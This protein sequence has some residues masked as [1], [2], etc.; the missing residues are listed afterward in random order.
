MKAFIASVVTETNT[1]AP[2]PTGEE[3]FAAYG[4]RKDTSRDPTGSHSEPLKV[5]RERAEVAGHDVVESLCAFAQPSGKTL[6]RVY[7]A[8]R[9]E[10]LDDLKAAGH[11]DVVLLMLHG[12]MVAEGYDDTEGDLIA[13]VRGVAP[14][15]VIGVELDPHCHLTEAMVAGADLI[16]ISKE[17][18]HVDFGERAVE[19]ADLCL[20][21]ARGELRPRAALVDCRMIG[22]YPTFDAP[23]KDIVDALKAAEMPPLLSVSLA[24]GF[25][26]ADVPEMGTRVL[27]Y[28]DDDA[29]AAASAAERFA[30]L[31]YD[32]R[33]ALYP[34]YPTISASLARA[35]NLEG[36]VVLGDFAD[37][38][39]GGAPGDATFFLREMLASGTTGAVVGVFWDPFVVSICADAGVGARLPVRLGGKC[40]PM[41][42][43]PLD[44]DVE[45]MGV[46]ENHTQGV[47]GQRESMGRSV[48]LRAHGND[49]AVCSVRTQTYDPDAFSGLGIDLEGRRLLVVKS[50]NHYRAGFDAIADHL[51]HVASPGTMSADLKSLP[52]TRLTRPWFPKVDDPWAEAG[53]PRAKVFHDR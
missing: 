21:T 26:W 12:A 30:R 24:H 49:I 47:Y 39:G 48:W 32:Q 34:D 31:I 42:G 27:V 53:P 37:N 18:P 25:P 52:Y 6:C 8:F 50:S 14:D 29:D 41:S 3:S 40:G 5:F 19:L 15:A 35:A 33:R 45:V 1:F 22:F 7:E 4:L 36:R 11:I 43:D 16:V 38:P 9:D 51:W 13:Q 44:L 46:V 20:A 2:F 28:A 10:I 17:Y 23:M